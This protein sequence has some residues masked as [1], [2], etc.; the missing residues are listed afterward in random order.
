MLENVAGELVDIARAAGGDA[1]GDDAAIAQAERILDRYDGLWQELAAEPLVRLGDRHAVDARIRRLNELGFAVEEIEM[2]P[3]AAAERG[4]RL[5][6]TV[7]GRRFHAE[8]LRALTGLA[9]GEG[10]AAILLADLHG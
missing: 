2:V 9:A 6:V 3:S 1:A 7:A 8:R 10:Q 4:L 5:R